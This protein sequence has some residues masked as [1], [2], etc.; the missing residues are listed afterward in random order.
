MKLVFLDTETTGLKPWKYGRTHHEILELAFIIIED[1]KEQRRE[2]WKFVPRRIH[3][4]SPEALSI[5]GYDEAEWK[6]D[7]V[8]WSIEYIN[9]L[10]EI[11]SDSVVIGHNISFD[12]GFLRAVFKDFDT[13]FRFPPEVDT[14]ALARIVWGFDSLR[15]DYIREQVPEMTCEGAHRALKDTEDCIFIYNKFIEMTRGKL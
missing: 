7:G 5:N 10:K 3:T 14:K 11:L 2:C 9:A 13:Y 12:I 6:K 4:A 8:E 15:M 1:G